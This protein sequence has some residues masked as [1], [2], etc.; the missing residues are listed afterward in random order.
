[1]THEMVEDEGTLAKV[2]SGP[3]GDFL[4]EALRTF[5]H[6]LMEEEVTA[7]VGAG[8]YERSDERL[9]RRNGH[10]EREWLTRLGS[11]SLSVPRLREAAYMPSFLEPRRRS[12]RALVAAIQEA[13]VLGLSTRKVDELVEALGGTGVSKSTV[14]RL[15][16][17]LDE[18]ARA[19]RDRPLDECLFSSW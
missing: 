4:R 14:S 13:Y 5:V 7:L 8:R 3:Q 6:K 9:A 1:M 12:E 15:C 2:L 18:E 17:E 11:M 19:F 16:A 10:R